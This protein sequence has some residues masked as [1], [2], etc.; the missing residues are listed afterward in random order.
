MKDVASS[1]CCTKAF[2]AKGASEKVISICQLYHLIEVI[3]HM[4]KQMLV[5]SKALYLKETV[6]SFYCRQS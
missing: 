6:G 5:F 3:I 2:S 1:S 4:E